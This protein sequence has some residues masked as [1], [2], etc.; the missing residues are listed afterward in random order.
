MFEKLLQ[1][2]ITSAIAIIS[3]FILTRIMGKKQMAQLNFFDYVIGISIGSIAAE[4][5]VVRS[6]QLAEGL[7]ALVIFT[8]F[9]LALSQIGLKSYR[10][11]RIL[12][13]SPSVLIENGNIIEENL[14]KVKLNINDLLEECRQKNIFDIKEIEFAIL[15]TSGRLSVQ[16]KSQNRPITP[17]DM[18]I[19][20]AYEGLCANVVI[21]G[22]IINENL[23]AL[24]LDSNW[25]H[26]ELSKQNI[27]ECT[28]VLL[29]Y[30]NTAGVL[31]TH[32][33]NANRSIATLHRL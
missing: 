5:A 12:D 9:S 28:D 30:V 7:T 23:D 22:K 14:Q 26:K 32:K 24:N 19:P 11:R 6:V 15:E 4:Y 18:N 21:D 3:L 31:H 8:I 1:T 17:K 33:K 25:L 13:G 2:A 10:G 27:S 29:A 20:T 16:P